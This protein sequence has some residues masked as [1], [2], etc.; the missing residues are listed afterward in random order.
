MVTGKK[1]YSSPAIKRHSLTALV[2]GG[3]AGGTEADGRREVTG[4]GDRPKG[5]QPPPR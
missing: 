3:S 1:P 4:G 2:K 5:S